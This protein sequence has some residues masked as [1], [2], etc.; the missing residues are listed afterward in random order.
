MPYAYHRDEERGYFDNVNLEEKKQHGVGAVA[1]SKQQ[2]SSSANRFVLPASV[3]HQVFVVVSI[4]LLFI[5]LISFFHILVDHAPYLNGK[6]RGTHCVAGSGEHFVWWTLLAI[7]LLYFIARVL[8]S[9]SWHAQQL[10]DFDGKRH[11]IQSGVLHHLD[12]ASDFR[13]S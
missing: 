1:Y 7:V 13:V 11:I 10:S 6:C 9:C 3:A 5:I 4:P 2:P 12:E 8:F